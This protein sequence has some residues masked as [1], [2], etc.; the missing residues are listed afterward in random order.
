MNVNKVKK[1]KTLKQRMEKAVKLATDAEE[2]YKALKKEI[3]G[4]MNKERLNSAN[5]GGLSLTKQTRK[6]VNVENWEK[7]YAYIYKNKSWDFLQKR[8]G[9][10]AILDRVDNGVKVPGIVISKFVDVRVIESKR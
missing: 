1:L 8:A 9:S 4:D 5:L 6:V 3:L 7:F 10:K 2:D